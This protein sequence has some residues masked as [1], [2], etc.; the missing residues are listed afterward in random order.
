MS[1]GCPD[2]PPPVLTVMTGGFRGHLDQ[3]IVLACCL[4]SSLSA[5]VWWQH[6]VWL[7]KMERVG[8]AVSFYHSV[9]WKWRKPIVEQSFSYRAQRYKIRC[10]LVS[11]MYLRVV[12][13]CSR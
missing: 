7:W 2:P 8:K 1:G 5:T 6:S 10:G 3:Q 11:E 9:V 12:T 13:Q 4:T